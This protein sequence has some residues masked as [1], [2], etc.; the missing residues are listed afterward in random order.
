MYI[1][2]STA[3]LGRIEAQLRGLRSKGPL[4]VWGVGE[5][6]KRLLATSELGRLNIAFF[7]DSNPLYN[8]K[9]LCG[10][11][12][13]PASALSDVDYPILV[14]SLVN[15]DSIRASIAGMHLDNPTYTLLPAEDQ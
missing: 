6:T 1:D 8:G 11:A 9:R 10:R 7:V 15:A 13:R 3:M 2:A 12:I 14:A 5:T 4:V